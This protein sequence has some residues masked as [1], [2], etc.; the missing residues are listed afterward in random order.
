[1]G[2]R[3]LVGWGAAVQ[4][5]ARDLAARATHPRGRACHLH[6]VAHV[7]LHV[8]TAQAGDPGGTG[9]ATS[10][11]PV[12]PERGDRGSEGQG[13]D[14]AIFAVLVAIVIAIGIQNLLLRRKAER[15]SREERGAER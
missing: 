9:I 1:M 5:L 15:E 12:P 10:E 7:A 3:S 2:P 4:P 14:P 13:F 6:S 11:L 8:E